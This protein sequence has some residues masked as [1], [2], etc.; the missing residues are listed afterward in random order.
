[1]RGWATAAVMSAVLGTAAWATQEPAGRALPQAALYADR[2]ALA[3]AELEALKARLAAR[4]A[5][6][7]ALQRQLQELEAQGED[8]AQAE[9]LGVAEAVRKSGLPSRAQ[10]RLAAAIVRESRENGL[11]P[12]LVVALIRTE[13]SFN[14]YAVS[15]VGAL[16]LMQVMP[17]TGKY[18]SKRLNIELGTRTHNLYDPETNVAMGT[19]Y[20]A[21][22][23]QR[24]GSV[25]RALV[26]YN[27]GPGNAK[28]ILAKPDVKKR[29]MAGYPK[30][31]VGEFRKLKAEQERLTLRT[32]A[33][34]PP[35]S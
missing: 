11:D 22:L 35:R 2:A 8:Y 16:G 9:R 7:A 12:M 29:F 28:R 19:A 33:D 6:V 15:H 26:A 32:D 34:T 3:G 31:V 24:F 17:D 21:D 5:E 20:L 13:S 27:A 30:K 18:L 14:P 25:D 1:M 23:I 4:D 10:R